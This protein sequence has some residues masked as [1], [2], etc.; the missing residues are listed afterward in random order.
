MEVITRLDRERNNVK[1]DKR[2]KNILYERWINISEQRYGNKTRRKKVKSVSKVGRKE[3]LC[4]K[5]SERNMYIYKLGIFAY[6]QKR[7]K[8]RR[9]NAEGEIYKAWTQQHFHH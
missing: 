8:C 4:K 9:L 7:E 6:D 3:I 5:Q 1:T 2:E